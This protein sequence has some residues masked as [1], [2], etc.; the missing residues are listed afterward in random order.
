M[1][2]IIC[3]KDGTLIKYLGNTVGM[4]HNVVTPLTGVINHMNRWEQQGHR[5]ILMT[6]RRESLR[7]K[8]EQ[9]LQGLGI[10]YDL[11]LMGHADTGRILI[12]DE[13]SKIKAHAVSLPRDSGFEDYE[14]E[15]VGLTKIKNYE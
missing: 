3:D 7:K 11:L 13:G 1:K 6:G 2:T 15:E 10:P 9:D 5:I 8:T 12:N 4:T 14:W